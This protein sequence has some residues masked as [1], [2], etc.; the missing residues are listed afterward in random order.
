MSIESIKKYS[1]KHENECEDI[2]SIDSSKLIINIFESEN[3][4]MKTFKILT[5]T[6]D[7]EYPNGIKT[8]IAFR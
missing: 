4:Y 1:Q 7:V 3:Q 2:V 8:S 5:L 6:K